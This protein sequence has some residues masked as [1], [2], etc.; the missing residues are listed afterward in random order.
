[1]KKYRLLLSAL[2]LAI[3]IAVFA[4][5]IQ[6]HPEVIRKLGEVSAVYIVVIA[7]LYLGIIATLSLVNS[8]SVRLCGKEIGRRESFNLT[9]TSSIANFF[10]PLQSGVG[11][12]A[13][14]LKKKLQIPIKQY[15]VV[16]LYYYG[17]YAFF[18]GIF[19]LFGN[20]TYRIPLLALTVLGSGSV[21]YYLVYRTKKSTLQKNISPELLIKLS[22]AVLLQL[23]LITTIYFLELLAL[24]KSV[25]LAQVISYSGAA[26]FSLFVAITPG[27]IGIREAF[28]VF[29]ERLHHID[30]ATVVAANVLDRGIYIIFLGILFCWLTATHAR[31]QMKA[32]HKSSEES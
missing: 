27:A 18:S 3:T 5:Y 30:S 22:G 20:E 9:A 4:R 19:L 12:R 11:I 15:A 10:G 32:Q 14:Y 21:I 7:L 26:N 31:V 23:A 8:I 17:L 28:L 13:L 6:T 1:M 29:S 25:S 2:V 24:G 16:S